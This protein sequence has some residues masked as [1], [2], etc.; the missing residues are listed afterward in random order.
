MLS[1]GN[2]QAILRIAYKKET[3]NMSTDRKNTILGIDYNINAPA[4]LNEALELCGGDE[5]VL[6]EHFVQKLVY[7]HHNA[8]VRGAFCEA[9]E[10][11]TG[12]ARE[13]KKVERNGKEVEVFAETE[14]EYVNRVC[15][16]EGVEPSEYAELLQEVADKHPLSGVRKARASSGGT[17]L[18]KMYITA[19]EEISKAGALEKAAAKLASDLGISVEATVESVALALKER[20]DR[21]KAE[22]AASIEAFVG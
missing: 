21:R 13:T 9:L 20:E 10:E 4:N 17:R 15:A 1:R 8:E 3:K 18:A 11:Q 5:A 12:H 6:V 19:A 22:F 2:R 16:L 7:N 14:T